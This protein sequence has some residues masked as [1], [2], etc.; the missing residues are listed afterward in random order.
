MPT[1]NRP[2]GIARQLTL[3]FGTVLLLTLLLLVVA[4]LG[5]RQADDSL[6]TLYEDRAVP[7]EQLGEMLYLNTRNRVLLTD[8]VLQGRPEVTVRRLQ[9]FD[10]NQAASE[11][12]WQ[13]YTATYLTDDEKR[14][15]ADAERARGALDSRGLQPLAAALR[16]GDAA[17]ARQLLDSQVSPLNPAY[18]QAL[19]ALLDLQ[20]QVA[21]DE[22]ASARV[23]AERRGWLMGGVAMLALGLGG[24]I[25]WGITRRLTRQLGTEPA[26][27]AALAG[28]IAA[29][30]L[31]DDQ[32]RPAPQGSVLASMQAMRADLAKLVAAVRR[33]VDSVATASSQIAQGNA[34]LSH[35]TEE[36]ASSLQQTAA[37]MEQLTGTVR[38][39]ADNARQASTLADTASHTAGRGGQAMAEVVQTMGEIRDASRRIGDIIGTIDGIAFQTNILAL[40]AAVEAARAGE[41]GR[42]FAVVAG[43]VRSLAQRS[44]QAAREIKSLISASVERVEAG[45]SLV[46]AA[47]ATMQEV[48]AQ[49]QQVST[50][51]DQI[52]RAAQE[53]TDGIGQVGQAV[54]LLDQT[55]QQNA[56]LVEQSAAAA[57][58]LKHQAGTLATSV[59][60]FRLD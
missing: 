37:A 12:R 51:I 17:T 59:A 39:S 40:N 2:W 48:V 41:Q 5:M 14:L 21:R 49:V 31:A 30:H 18:T 60:V 50:L 3:G 57:E 4:G 10:K 27:L 9:E 52:T 26:D 6:K 47:G 15:V 38:Q 11:R 13:A 43:E 45:D 33:S 24:L 20:V 53:Q 16:R 28:R 44:A 54:S 56:A 42:G 8:A 36:Q 22:Y 1:T 7:L 58:S 35:R 55:T 23:A 29:G 34:D 25:G 32:A 46:D 19:Q